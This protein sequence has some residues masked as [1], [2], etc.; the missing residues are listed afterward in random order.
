MDIKK[1][2]DDFENDRFVDAKDE[3]QSFVRDRVNTFIKD[4]LELQNEV[5]SKDH[6]DEEDESS[7]KVKRGRPMKRS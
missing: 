7:K 1:A 3:I 2:L 4:R 6:D 5:C